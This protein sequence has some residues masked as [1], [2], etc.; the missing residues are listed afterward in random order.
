MDH[1]LNVVA[2][3]ALEQYLGPRLHKYVSADIDGKVEFGATLSGVIGG[4]SGA[5]GE[6]TLQTIGIDL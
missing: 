5:L 3:N 4:H 6:S 2:N 1:P